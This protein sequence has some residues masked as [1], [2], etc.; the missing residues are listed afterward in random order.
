MEYNVVGAPSSC[1]YIRLINWEEGNYRVTNKPYPQGE[2][3]VGG[4]TV[5]KGYYKLPGKTEEEFFE[6]DGQ[7]WFRTGD[8][9]EVHHDGVLKIIGKEED[10]HVILYRF[11]YSPLFNPT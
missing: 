1:N 6:E 11:D 7:R 4:A 9:G 10:S 5:S 8:I 3:V 2:I